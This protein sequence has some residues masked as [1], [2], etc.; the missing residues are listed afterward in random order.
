[1]SKASNETGR[2]VADMMPRIWILAKKYG[3]FAHCEE[4][5]QD[6]A[7]K[8][9]KMEAGW[10]SRRTIGWLPA[11]VRSV[12]VNAYRRGKWEARYVDRS[13]ALD[14]SGAVC[15]GGEHGA[16]L[17][18]P[19]A[20]STEQME[21][22]LTPMVKE[23]VRKLPINQ[24]K[25]LVLHAAGFGHGEIARFTGSNEGTVKSRLHYAR[26]RAQEMLK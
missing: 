2:L 20:P 18:V 6:V 21:H 7:E 26:K 12:A 5:A 25:V 9:L 15:E 8:L 17:Y 1:M 16:P 11:V 10:L 4:V 23:V 13:L 14:I 24:R 19:A 3:R 22:Y